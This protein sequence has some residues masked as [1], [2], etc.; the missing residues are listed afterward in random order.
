MKTQE[1]NP[2][3]GYCFMEALI[4]SFD[5][6]LPD[7]QVSML[8]RGYSVED[9][10]KLEVAF[11]R[12]FNVCIWSLFKNVIVDRIRVDILED[13]DGEYYPLEVHE[14]NEV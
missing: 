13:N 2:Q 14:L 12:G 3:E 11:K 8:E 4:G 9:L 1:L 5:N 7:F 6:I 10:D